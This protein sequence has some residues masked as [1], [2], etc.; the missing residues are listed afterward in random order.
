VERVEDGAFEPLHYPEREIHSKDVM[1]LV[2]FSS[3]PQMER[4]QSN[5]LPAAP[6]VER[7]PQGLHRHFAEARRIGASRQQ[8]YH[9][10]IGTTPDNLKAKIFLSA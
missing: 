2:G 6:L 1:L 9:K 10:L 5:T 3:F 7:C 8:Q 4:V